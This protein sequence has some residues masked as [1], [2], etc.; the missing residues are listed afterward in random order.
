MGDQLDK[1][2]PISIRP[3]Q[4]LCIYHQLKVS[5]CLNLVLVWDSLLMLVYPTLRGG[6]YLTVGQREK[7][8]APK[9]SCSELSI[10]MALQGSFTLSPTFL[11]T[12]RHKKE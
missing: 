11:P 1:A 7:W 6:Q 3:G 9:V 5:V 12:P 2:L 10:V 8:N 4:K